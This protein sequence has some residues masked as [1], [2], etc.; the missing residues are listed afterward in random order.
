MP[1]CA[2][3]SHPSSHLLSLAFFIFFP[4][5]SCVATGL[6]NS[7]TQRSRFPGLATYFRGKPLALCINGCLHHVQQIWHQGLANVQRKPQ[8]MDTYFRCVLLGFLNLFSWGTRLEGRRVLGSILS[9]GQTVQ[10]FVNVGYD[11]FSTR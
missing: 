3:F 10:S 4:F 6:A 8:H 11:K 7:H 1:I 5:L 9:R 2:L